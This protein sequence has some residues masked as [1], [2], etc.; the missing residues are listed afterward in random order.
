MCKKKDKTI[1]KYLCILCLFRK[2]RQNNKKVFT[3][4]FC[5]L[6]SK[7]YFCALFSKKYFC[8]HFFLKSKKVFKYLNSQ[9]FYR[10]S[11]CVSCAVSGQRLLYI[12]EAVDSAA[13]AAASRLF[14]FLIL[15]GYC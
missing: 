9:Y 4:S 7:K 2:G 8:A 6:F 3:G 14:L 13:A 10:F 1:K 5:I 11:V 12:A 15:K